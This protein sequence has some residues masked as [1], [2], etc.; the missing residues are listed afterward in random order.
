[1]ANKFPIW[2]CKIEYSYQTNIRNPKSKLYF[3]IIMF[4]TKFDEESIKTNPL[5]S[6]ELINKISPK[7]PN[8]EEALKKIKILKIEKLKQYGFTNY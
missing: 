8:K 7:P 1:M 6:R 4:L 2:E 5:K 3:S